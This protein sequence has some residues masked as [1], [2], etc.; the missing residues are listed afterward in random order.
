MKL[1][2]LFL[3]ILCLSGSAM[4]QV[5]EDQRAN[6]YID[7]IILAVNDL[8]KGMDE[9]HR[10]TGVKPRE[11]GSNA[12]LGTR[13]AVIALGPRTY[14][15]IMAPDPEADMAQT[16]PDLRPLVLDTIRGFESLTPFMWVIGTENMALSRTLARRVSIHTQDP[17]RGERQKGWRRG[18]EWDW[19]WIYRPE[20]RVT[21][22]FVQWPEDARRPGDRAPGDCTLSELR[23]FSKNYKSVQGLIA[24]TQVEAVPVG[25]DEDALQFTLECNGE[26]IVFGPVELTETIQPPAAPGH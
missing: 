10:L 24:A 19:T 3:A 12:Q 8:D 1:F 23:A 6:H 5:P 26:E 21:P 22:W 17:L 20:S 4:G 7:H 18:Y 25:A 15:E 16:D 9:V 2:M 11:D 14:L 13:S